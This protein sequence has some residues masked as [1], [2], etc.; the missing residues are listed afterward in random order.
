MVSNADPQATDK[1]NKKICISSS[2]SDC[3]SNRKIC[4]PYHSSYVVSDEISLKTDSSDFYH[5]NENSVGLCVIINQRKF[6]KEEDPSWQVS[7]FL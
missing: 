4:S 6:Y 3:S 2:T 1:K 7:S 5:I